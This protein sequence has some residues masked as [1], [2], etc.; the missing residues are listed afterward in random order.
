M[1]AFIEELKW[2]GLWADMTPGTE[3]QLNKE[4]TTAYIGF[5]PTAD[6]LHIGSLIPIKILAHFQRHGHKPIALVGGATGMIGD[7]SGKSAE[8]NLLD[9]E[10]LLYYVDCLK[11]QLSRFLDF[12]GD[13][14]NRAE[15]VNNYD[16]MKNVTFLDFAKNIG[17]HIT[18]NYMMAKDS[19]KKRF[20]GED[21]ADGMSF[22][23]F[24]YQ[25]LQGYDYLHLYKEKGVK[26]QMGGSDQWGNI[27]TGTELIRRKAQGEA[28]ALTTKLITK[29]DG[30]KFGKSESGENYWLDAKRTS[31]YR[32]YQF[33]LN[34]TDEDGERFIKF[35][36]FLEKEEIDKL[37]EEHRTAP[38]ERKLQKKLAEEVTVWV[39]GRA[40]YER[41]LKASEILFGRS[42]AEDLVSLDEELFLQIF[43][44]VPQKEV[45][46]SEVIGSNIVDLI[47]DKSG[48]LK[49]KGE[50]KREL[51]GNAISVNKE[52]VNDTFEVS[53]KDLIDGKF[54][55]LQK[56]KKSYFIVKTV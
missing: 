31:P 42:T 36:T 28:F 16:W 49:S 26:L 32:F 47:S 10:T 2:R 39:H 52:K 8:R 48:F 12:E 14:P 44:G 50:A 1:N 53:E 37:I 22:T 35:Y 43:D 15:L 33:W 7:P 34:A 17:K 21:G 41:A 38:H 51:S 19:V 56:G 6:S 30:S 40:E 4:M 3:D 25:L 45:A 29:A 27:T 11:N 55:L 5:D 24:T 54:L 23:E 18:V 46:K 20:S 13:G 9:E